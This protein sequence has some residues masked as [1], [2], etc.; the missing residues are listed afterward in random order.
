MTVTVFAMIGRVLMDISERYEFRD[1]RQDEAEQAA[2]IELICFPPHEACDRKM[3]LERVRMA[4]DVFLVAV[5]RETGMIAGFI[6]GAATDEDRFSDDFFRD[7][8]K[9]DPKGR[10][11]MILGV[12]VLPEHRHKGLAQAMMSVYCRRESER[13]RRRLILTCLEDKVGMYRKWGYRDLGLSASTWGNE[14]WHEMD[15]VLNTDL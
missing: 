7:A 15:I 10:N 14:E 2:E 13:G 3:M 9:H 6:N 1:I 12:D 4:P 8:G 11:I 5:D